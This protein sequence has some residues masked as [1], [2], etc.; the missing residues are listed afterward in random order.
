MVD[1][2]SFE[3]GPMK[4]WDSLGCPEVRPLWQLETNWKKLTAIDRA[5]LY[6]ANDEKPVLYP[7]RPN[8]M[9]QF[10]TRNSRD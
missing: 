3:Q 10:S 2:Y 9:D 1:S 4:L 8:L 7:K 5:R 6:C